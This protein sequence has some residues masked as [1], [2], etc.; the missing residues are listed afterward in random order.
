MKKKNQAQYYG[1]VSLGTP[2][3]TFQVIFDTGSSNLW[4][5]SSKCKSIACLL[6]NQYDSSKSHTYK[7]DGRKF[8]IQYGTGHVAGF[9]SKD[10]FGIGTLHA[11]DLTFG[12]VTEEGLLPFSTA[13]FDGIAG[14]AFPSIAVQQVEPF[15]DALMRQKAVDQGQFSFYLT[16][17]ESKKTPLLILGGSDTKYYKEPVTWVPLRNETYWLVTMDKATA[18]GVTIGGAFAAVDTGTSM[19]AGPAEDILSIL[20]VARVKEDCSNIDSLPPVTFTINGKDFTL[21]PHDYVV[22]L[23]QFG[24]TQCMS[25]FLPIALP[26]GYPKLFILGD[27]FLRKYYSIYD[28]DNLRVGL[29]EAL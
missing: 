25:G 5:P 19:I 11:S 23:S 3:Q 12:E 6:H 8:E 20:T 22:K 24:Q 28:R 29:A 9:L 18:G 14:L 2:A 26:T 17:G 13:G 7:A 15:F 16:T 10:D 4:I 21:S 1:P 27:V